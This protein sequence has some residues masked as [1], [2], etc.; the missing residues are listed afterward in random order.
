[1]LLSQLLLLITSHKLHCY[2][3]QIII[4]YDYWAFKINIF[5]IQWARVGMIIIL[6]ETNNFWVFTMWYWETSILKN[7]FTIFLFYLGQQ[8]S[9][10]QNAFLLGFQLSMFLSLLPAPSSLRVPLFI[11]FCLWPFQSQSLKRTYWLPFCQIV[12]YSIKQNHTHENS[13]TQV[14]LSLGTM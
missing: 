12:I 1:M 14:F 4:S 3:S 10:W 2:P 7:K 5:P 13:Y 6:I 8:A 11:F 9:K